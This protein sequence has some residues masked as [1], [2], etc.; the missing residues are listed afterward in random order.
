MAMNH[1][2]QS[3]RY[4]K[5][6]FFQTLLNY[7]TVYILAGE[8]EL[9]FDYVSDPRHVQQLIMDTCNRCEAKRQLEEE[10]RRRAY[11]SDLVREIQNETAEYQQ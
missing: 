4:E 6:G 9:S 11:I 1:K 3:V 5:N 2:I 10:A 8:G 7:G